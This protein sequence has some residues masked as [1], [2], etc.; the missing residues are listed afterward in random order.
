MLFAEERFNNA[1]VPNNIT[2]ITWNTVKY[3]Q[4]DWTAREPFFMCKRMFLAA[5][6]FLDARD[7]STLPRTGV[8]RH[9]KRGRERE[10]VRTLEA[11]TLDDDRQKTR[12]A[13]PGLSSL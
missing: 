13:I 11:A 6:A 3:R 9:E 8:Y 5:L 7:S 1:N 12:T 2:E 10:R 4:A